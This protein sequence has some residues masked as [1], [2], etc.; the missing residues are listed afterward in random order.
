MLPAA[1][2]AWPDVQSPVNLHGENAWRNRTLRG[3]AVAQHSMLCGACS[4]L[5]DAGWHG[6]LRVNLHGTGVCV[7]H[8]R[9]ALYARRV[10]RSWPQMLDTLRSGRLRHKHG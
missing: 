10:A 4:S 6:M 8:T 1:V 2:A 3:R 9:C 7:G 5:E